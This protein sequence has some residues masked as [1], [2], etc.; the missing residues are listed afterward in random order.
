MRIESA[1]DYDT[2]AFAKA[3][4]FKLRETFCIGYVMQPNGGKLAAVWLAKN[5]SRLGGPA[6]EDL[7]RFVRKT[8]AR[9]DQKK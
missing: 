2:A 7:I 1:G 9:P 6:H 3:H 5:G 4:V 8:A